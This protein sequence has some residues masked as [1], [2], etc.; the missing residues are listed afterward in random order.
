MRP[1]RP[2]LALAALALLAGCTTVAPDGGFGAVAD[3]SHERIGARPALARDEAAARELDAAVRAELARPLDM[4][5]AVRVALVN[6]PGLQATYWQV[7][8]AQ[9]ELAQAARLHN[10]TLGFRRLSG[11][12]EVEI[13]RGLSFDLAGIL[14][15]PLARRIEAR[16]FERVRREVGAAIERHAADTRRA[17]VEAVAARQHLDY[18]RQVNAAAEA[19]AELADRMARAGN[20][21]RLDLAREQ[22]FHAESG[23][24]LA[25]AVQQETAARERL[26]RLLG[27]WGRDAG[28][29][30]PERLP[31][32]P[33]APA[34][35]PDIER[36]ALERRLDVQAAKTE[37]RATADSLGLTRTTRFINALELGYAGKSESGAPSSRGYELSI[38]L[39]LFDWGG[40]RVARAEAIYMQALQRVAETAVTARSEARESY[41]AYRNAYDVARHYRDTVIPLRKQVS[42]EVLLRYNGMLASPQDL[43][44]DAREQAAAVNAAIEAQRDFWRA[45]AELES[46]LGARVGAGAGHEQ[47]KEHAE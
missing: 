19:G 25:R 21:A 39:P 43:L 3:A 40:A 47:H 27:L 8:I 12:G 28:F 30:L 14:T 36:I 15:M 42:R 17:W 31:E 16:R 34:E 2:A 20:I 46:A 7:G 38:E 10:P 29:T 35:L 6:H 33:A 41:L 5:G 13:E 22:L 1:Q 37:A 18:A 26:T 4:D 32:L 23:A 44:S 45:Q 24:A 11:G 9:A